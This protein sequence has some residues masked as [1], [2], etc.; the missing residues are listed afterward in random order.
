MCG[1]A[2]SAAEDPNLVEL[3]EFGCPASEATEIAGGSNVR[4]DAPLQL[5]V[6]D[7]GARQNGQALKFVNHGRAT[8]W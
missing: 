2:R 1:D 7:D 3:A 5:E 8:G 4:V 6:P